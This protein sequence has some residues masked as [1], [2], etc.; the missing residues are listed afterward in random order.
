[1]GLGAL[2]KRPKDFFNWA[3]NVH[4]LPKNYKSVALVSRRI[5]KRQKNKNIFLKIGLFMYVQD[6]IILLI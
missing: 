2:Y 1:M 6:L 5:N 3:L 4:N